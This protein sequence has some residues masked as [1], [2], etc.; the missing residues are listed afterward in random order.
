MRS[1]NLAP[2]PDQWLSHL[3]ARE[4]DA[5]RDERLPVALAAHRHRHCRRLHDGRR[6]HPHGQDARCLGSRRGFP[7][8]GGI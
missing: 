1:Q 2:L 7:S 5:L 3:G 4:L 8:H 6:L